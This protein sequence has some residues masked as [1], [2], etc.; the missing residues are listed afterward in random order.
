MR[1]YSKNGGK[2]RNRYLARSEIIKVKKQ[3]VSY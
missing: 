1:L 2:K 3:K